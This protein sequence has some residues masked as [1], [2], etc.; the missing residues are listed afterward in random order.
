MIGWG[1]AENLGRRSDE[2]SFC[3]EGADHEKSASKLSLP[4]SATAVDGNDMF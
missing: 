2:S 1:A 3:F 4:S